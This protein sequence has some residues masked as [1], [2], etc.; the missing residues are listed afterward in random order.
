MVI[1]NG[2]KTISPE[3][4]GILILRIWMERDPVTGLRARI[5][6]ALDSTG[7]EKQI[8]T[9]STPLAIY[10]IVRDWVESFVAQGDDGAPREAVTP[11]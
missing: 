2:M 8:A 10:G 5:T 4:S 7:T 11:G 9:A 1:V 6:H 3:K